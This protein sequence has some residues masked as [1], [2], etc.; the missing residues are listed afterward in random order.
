MVRCPRASGRQGVVLLSVII[1]LVTISLI[2]AS[3]L[4]FITSVN[5]ESQRIAEET[6]AYYLAEAGFVQSVHMLRNQIQVEQL[7]SEN[8][9]GPI[10][11]GE[12]TYRVR[13]EQ[14]AQPVIVSVGE[15]NGTKKT[16]QLQYMVL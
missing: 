7:Y 13:L 12:G 9:Y 3:L 5:L 11:L 14:Q 8:G 6:K 16:L 2:G 10:R 1:V 4:S 15:V